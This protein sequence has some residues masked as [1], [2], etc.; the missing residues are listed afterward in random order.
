MTN[1]GSLGPSVAGLPGV[2]GSVTYLLECTPALCDMKYATVKYVP[3]LLVNQI[4][5]GLFAGLLLMQIIMLF[6]W[7]TWSYTAMM[8]CGLLLECVGY[9]GRLQ[10]HKNIFDINPFLM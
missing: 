10:M 4:F 8:F 2:A 5:L 7:R 6:F 1:S 9:F 3:N